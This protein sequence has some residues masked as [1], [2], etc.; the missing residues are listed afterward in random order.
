MTTEES[1][2]LSAFEKYKGHSSDLFDNEE[3]AKSDAFRAGV[4]FALKIAAEKV[5]LI[6]VSFCGRSKSQIHIGDTFKYNNDDYV[7]INKHSI[8]NCLK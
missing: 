4:E 1:K 8:L 7:E 3:R 6:N 5:N 2:I